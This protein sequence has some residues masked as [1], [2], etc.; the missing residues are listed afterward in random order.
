MTKDDLDIL[1]ELINNALESYLDSGYGLNSEYTI[2]L[3]NL[4]NKLG[5]KEYWDYDKKYGGE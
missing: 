1:E 5:L 3:R 2:A 4:L